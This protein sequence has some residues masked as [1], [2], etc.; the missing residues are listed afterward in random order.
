MKVLTTH[1]NPHL[2]DICAIWLFKKFYPQFKDVKLDFFSASQTDHLKGKETKDRIFFGI[3]KGRFDE[4]KG[5]KNDCATSLVWKEII[6]EGLAPKKKTV[7]SA[8]KRIVEWSRRI[9]LGKTLDEVNPF[10]IPAFIRP[11]DNSLESSKKA[12]ELGCDILDR[13]LDVSIQ[14]EQSKKDW[15]GAVEFKSK[16]G[17]SYA[18]ASKTI[19]RSF[20]KKR[21]GDLFLIYNPKY[22]SVQFFTPKYNLDLEPLYKKLKKG[23]PKASWFLHHSHHI[24]LCGSGSAPDSHPT[25][26]SFGELVDIAKTI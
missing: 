22:P 24:L 8:F 3:G 23:D 25:K 1:I 18:V 13:V 19:T 20:C 21:G 10:S 14:N 12:V 6:K 16:F 2:D 15:R 26:F 11:E 17:K 7:F 4:H 5:D 9:D